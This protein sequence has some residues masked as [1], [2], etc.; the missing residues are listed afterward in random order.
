MGMGHGDYRFVD[1]KGQD[2]FQIYSKNP[3]TAL[4]EFGC[5]GPSSIET[6]KKCIPEEDLFPP[7]PGT[8]WETHHAYG[9]W[10]ADPGSWLFLHVIEKYFGKQ[11]SLEEIVKN[12]QLLQA[13]GYQFI[14][15]EARRNKR[16]LLNG[17]QLVL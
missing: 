6:L 16:L 2:L 4:P 10:D 9:S 7:R 8:A 13:I 3:A 5:P 12:G 11:E 14:F 17:A 1:D 15:E